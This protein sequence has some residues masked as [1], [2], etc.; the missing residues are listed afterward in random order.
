[1]L[2]SNTVLLLIYLLYTFT[3]QSNFIR[4]FQVWILSFLYIVMPEGFI[5]SK[6]A[7]ITEPIKT[8]TT[9]ICLSNWAVLFSHNFIFDE[10]RVITKD[11]QKIYS[12]G[13]SFFVVLILLFGSF[14]L[15]NLPHAISIINFGRVNDT[16]GTSISPILVGISNASGHVL[17]ATLAFYFKNIKKSKNYVFRSF[18]FSFPIFL[19]LFFGG[20]RFHL[21]FSFGG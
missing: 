7:I 19:I 5:Y 6:L 2:L 10:S 16:S 21:L 17:P 3:T 18:C 15:I 14:L 8:A 4:L 12:A 1:M 11:L 20:T 13:I 9:Y